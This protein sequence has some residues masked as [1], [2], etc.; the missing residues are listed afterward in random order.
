MSYYQFKEF[1]FDPMHAMLRGPEGEQS[2]EHRVA[3][4][5]EYFC[6][7]PQQVLSKES[8]LEAVW[9]GRIVNEDSLSVAVSKLRKILQD[10]RGEPTF[11]KT[12]P[13]VG[14]CWLPDTEVKSHTNP[15]PDVGS[16]P[17]QLR[18][19]QRRKSYRFGIA[20]LV[21]LIVS[22]IAYGIWSDRS[23]PETPASS[24]MAD[25]SGLS[26][27]LQRKF[28]EAQATVEHAVYHE[29]TIEDYR[30]AIEL[31]RDILRE[32][33][34]YIPAHLGIGEAKFEMSGQQGYQDLQ[35]YID[36]LT[37]IA[38]LALAADPNNGD[39]LELKAKIAFL[40]TWEL[41]RAAEYY[42]RAIEAMPDDPG[43]YLGY[44]EFLIT[45]GNI[46][47]AKN[48]LRQLRQKD[49]DFFRYTNLSLVYMFQGDYN[50]AKAETQRL[51]NSE[52]ASVVHNAILHRLGVV[53]GD[54]ALAM[55]HLEILMRQLQNYP[56]QR[57]ADYQALFAGGGI[58][59]VYQQLL[60]ERNSDNLGQ[61]LPPLSWA[62]YA[63]VAGET[64]QALFHLR[65]AIK[66]KQPQVLLL[67][68]DPHYDPLRPLIEF[69]ALA[70]QV[71][72]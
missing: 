15:T 49:P 13:G 22:A 59:A 24:T 26:P 57:V 64:E 55:E 66:Q 29:I 44:S 67:H 17:Q 68:Q 4:L 6:Q 36:E 14:Y 41:D 11:I 35:L 46:A 42:Q 48:M 7:H 21:F 3:S 45:R 63:I 53:S 61:Y 52:A 1:E 65:N 5:L 47:E 23:K 58:K 9:A 51:I 50:K 38:N 2:L 39:A 27:E 54:D 10:S 32:H 72:N 56:E 40:G 60:D 33:P 25:I 28:K 16:A 8:L 37:T 34:D 69:Q 31:F 20:A 62:R 12:V 18:R 70:A 19:V 71:P 30:Q 43:I